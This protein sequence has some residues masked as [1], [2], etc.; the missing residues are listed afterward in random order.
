MLSKTTIFMQIL[1]MVYKFPICN[2]KNLHIPWLLV[3][4]ALRTHGGQCTHLLA[5]FQ[6]WENC[7]CTVL[8]F[9]H[10]KPLFL[11]ETFLCVHK[12]LPESWLLHHQPWHGNI[13]DCWYN[14]S[15]AIKHKIWKVFF[16]ENLPTRELS[17][18]SMPSNDAE[19]SIW[20]HFSAS[21][22]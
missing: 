7:L 3:L 21:N 4:H 22:S 10:V 13:V 9:W 11:N 5:I 16:A 8:F 6:E 12:L 1:H 17:L 20:R 19:K 15:Q 14:S 18:S 2:Y